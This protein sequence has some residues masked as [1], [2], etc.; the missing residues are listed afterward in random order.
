MTSMIA[1]PPSHAGSP[2]SL[3][4]ARGPSVDD[5]VTA[6]S[7]AVAGLSLEDPRWETVGA[8]LTAVVDATRLACGLAGSPIGPDEPVAPTMRLRDLGRLAQIIAGGRTPRDLTVPRAI[9]EL[10]WSLQVA[11]A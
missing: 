4:V 9:E 5:V 10:L 6:A 7:D 11:A 3:L 2:R 8:R 1:T